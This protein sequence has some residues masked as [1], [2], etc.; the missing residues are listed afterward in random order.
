MSHINTILAKAALIRLVIFD[1]DG[2]FTDGGLHYGDDGS[3]FKVF[4]SRDGHG[5]KM[6]QQGGV[7]IAVISG[8][9]GA[10][11]ERRMSELGVRHVHLGIEDKGAVFAQLLQQLH[12]R[13]QQTAYVGDDIVD[14]PVM[15]R[16]GLAIAVQDA[17]AFVR[18]HAHWCTTRPGGRGAVREVCELI[19]RA[20]GQLDKIRSR[21][22]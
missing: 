20:Q 1:V 9:R 10:A 12:F 4:N 19:L 8:R 11:T 13:P 14:L 16:V 21:Y 3:E 17:D 6:L 22:L 18:Y 2:V 5:I 15:N 7:A